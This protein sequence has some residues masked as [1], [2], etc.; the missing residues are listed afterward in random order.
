MLAD[1]WDHLG[2]AIFTQHRVNFCTDHQLEG[3]EWRVGVR[4]SPD[5]AGRQDNLATLDLFGD[6]LCDDA[7]KTHLQLVSVEKILL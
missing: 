2:A 6:M 7:E 5:S 3:P 1:R 4:A